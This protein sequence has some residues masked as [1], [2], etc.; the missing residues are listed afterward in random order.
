M[1]VETS[2]TRNNDGSTAA[3]LTTTTTGGARQVVL[4]AEDMA[5]FLGDQRRA[6]LAKMAEL[7]AHFPQPGDP[8]E[9]LSSAEA[10][11]LVICMHS[12]E[13]LQ[14]GRRAP[15]LAAPPRAT[16]SSRGRCE[17]RLSAESPDPLAGFV[18][19]LRTPRV[20]SAG[21]PPSGE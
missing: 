11:L 8:R 9:L 17:R 13:T 7:D 10:K 20:W 12:G 1:G 2:A 21:P 6:L 16:A 3:A 5:A 15:P 14:V 4:S 18:V 19:S